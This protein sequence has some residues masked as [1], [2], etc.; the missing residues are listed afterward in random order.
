MSISATKKQSDC[1]SSENQAK[2]KHLNMIRNPLMASAES[3]MPGDYEKFP[4]LLM[5]HIDS[6]ELLT[7]HGGT[8]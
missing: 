6:P 5:E 7:K 1:N 4:K 3:Q 2:A 8:I